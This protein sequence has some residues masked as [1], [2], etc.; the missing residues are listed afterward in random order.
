MEYKPGSLK[1]KKK[2]LWVIFSRRGKKIWE[3]GIASCSRAVAPI[4]GLRREETTVAAVETPL[5][6]GGGCPFFSVFSC[7]S[8][9]D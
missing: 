3:I 9:L 1:K 2:K 4:P 7:S 8:T 5:S 6:R